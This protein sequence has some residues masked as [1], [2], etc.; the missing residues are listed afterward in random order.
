M[1]KTECIYVVTVNGAIHEDTFTN[2]SG[3]R[4]TFPLLSYRLLLT[5]LKDYGRYTHVSEGRVVS[6]FRC[7]VVR[8]ANRGNADNFKGKNKE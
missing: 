4:D 5:G 2:P 6:V 8:S 3:V 1:N 7:S